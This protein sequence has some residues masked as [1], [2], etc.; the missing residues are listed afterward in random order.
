MI[1]RHTLLN[2]EIF[3]K[4][5]YVDMIQRHFGIKD[6]KKESKNK[7]SEFY[8]QYDILLDIFKTFELVANCFFS[9]SNISLAD[10]TDKA[11]D[12]VEQLIYNDYENSQKHKYTVRSIKGLCDKKATKLYNL[13]EKWQKV[14]KNITPKNATTSVELREVIE[15]IEKELKELEYVEFDSVV[16]DNIT[17]RKNE[18]KYYKTYKKYIS[19]FD[20]IYSKREDFI[21]DFKDNYY[22]HNGIVLTEEDITNFTN[23]FNTISYGNNGIINLIVESSIDTT[24]LSERPTDEE[25]YKL[26]LKQ[27]GINYDSVNYQVN[28]MAF[29]LS[30][31][32]LYQI[33]NKKMGLSFLEALCGYDLFYFLTVCE[34]II[35]TDKIKFSFV[36][37]DMNKILKDLKDVYNTIKNTNMTLE[38]VCEDNQKYYRETIIPA[39]EII[40][41]I[42]ERNKDLFMEMS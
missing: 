30:L 7:N 22:K 10:K 14:F 31:E 3:K 2:D 20:P 39:Y 42:I 28:V 13:M 15:K 26:Y 40:K 19:K 1:E 12:Y 8:G 5:K 9:D 17:Y 34:E 4:S 24:E 16:S 41:D 6:L 23:I 18:I 25:I 33:G 38:E 21:K 27:N 36:A 11:R 29:R 37:N 35:L 32:K